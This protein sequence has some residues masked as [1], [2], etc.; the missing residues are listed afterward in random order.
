MR[1]V[2]ASSLGL[3]VVLFLFI[4]FAAPRGPGYDAP[5]AVACVWASQAM[6]KLGGPGTPPMSLEATSN[7]SEAGGYIV[8]R[9]V[10]GCTLY[11]HESRNGD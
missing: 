7:R 2:V 11:F 3:G 10:L 1:L 4:L 6:A 8:E 9:Q 5:Q